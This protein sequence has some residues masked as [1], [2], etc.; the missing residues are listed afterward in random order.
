VRTFL[1]GFTRLK[2]STR[3][4]RPSSTASA[5]P[6]KSLGRSSDQPKSTSRSGNLIPEVRT[7]VGPWRSFIQVR[8][9]KNLTYVDA[10][11]WKSEE[12]AG[13]ELNFLS[14]SQGKVIAFWVRLKGVHPFGFY[15]LCRPLLPP[16][17]SSSA[18]MILTN[19]TMSM[20]WV[21]EGL[22]LP[23][24]QNIFPLKAL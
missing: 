15:V 17:A 18:S 24:T 7:N 10:H 5:S 2:V 3:T 19:I 22:S 23:P 6:E 20:G 13:G 12:G 8:K 21:G 1:P 4:S 16:S 14:K 9:L 11:G